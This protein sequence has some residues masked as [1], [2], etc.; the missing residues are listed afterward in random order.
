MTA[1]SRIT[2]VIFLATGML[3]AL[4]HLAS[5]EPTPPAPKRAAR[6]TPTPA[7]PAGLPAGLDPPLY[8]PGQIPFHEGERLVYQASWIGI[9]AATARV[10][11]HKNKKDPSLLQAEAWIQTNQAVDLLFRMRDYMTEQMQPESLVPNQMYIR[12]SENQRLN[13]FRVTFDR[14]EGLVTMV[15]SNRKGKQVKQF[16]SKN[17]WGPL[18]GAMMALSL[19]LTPGQHYS[20]DVFTGSSRYVFDFKV[21]G[22]EKITTALGTFDALRLIPGVLYESSGKLTQSATGTT[23]WVT[24]D[25]RHLPLR[26]EAQAFIGKVRADLIQVGG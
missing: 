23:I 16:L 20:V 26:A 4:P 3:L 12:Q 9:P 8:K 14:N 24:A 11:L 1:K 17:P 13:D 25:G 2:A 15:K 10:E 18:S 6:P 5:P 21:A 7:P 19:P 22:R